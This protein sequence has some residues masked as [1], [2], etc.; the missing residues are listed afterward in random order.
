MNHKMKTL[1]IIGILA[2]GMSF[3]IVSCSKEEVTNVELTET[4]KI[5]NAFSLDSF[6]NPFVKNNLD[7]NWNDFQ[8]NRNDTSSLTYEF[9]TILKA[10]D[11]IES[12]ETK[13]FFKYKLKV[14]EIAENYWDF[15]IIKFI[16]DDK[17]S[18]INIST[19]FLGDF[20]G[21]MV[22]FNLKGKLKDIKGLEKGSEIKPKKVKNTL[23]NKDIPIPTDSDPKDSGGGS[24]QWIE[25][26][27][28]TDWYKVYPNGSQQYTHSVYNYTSWEYVYVPYDSYYPSSYHNHYSNNSSGGGNYNHN[29][30]IIVEE[31]KIDNQLTG[32]ALC[33]Y[34]KLEALNGNLFK[35]TIGKFI[36]DPKYDLVFQVGNCAT[37][38]DAC[39]NASN[40]NSTG[41]IVITIEDDKQNG[42]GIAAL[43]LHEGIHAEIHRFVSRYESGVDPNDRPR[44][45]Q[46]FQHYHAAYKTGDIHHIYMTENYIIP[47]A[48]ALRQLDGNKYP[49]DYYKAFAW[50]GLRAWDANSLLGMQMDTQYNDYQTTVLQNSNIPCD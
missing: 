32:K 13:L 44:L 28:Y 7:I 43:I 37:T 31:D 47:I 22:S 46:L 33:I 29:N 17:K 35:T 18:L 8:T 2:L 26:V 1:F 45:F 41:E 16:T 38:N 49:I 50:D 27:N 36:K 34:N 48:S 24:F 11:F 12:G 39:T 10:N 6:D 15:E 25:I 5:R 19:S 42:L 40:I 4:Q 23:L 20:S 9:N 14:F 21:T 3:L 30:E